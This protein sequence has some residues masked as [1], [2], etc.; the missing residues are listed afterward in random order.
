MERK[1][2]T[3]GTVASEKSHKNIILLLA[4]A[5]I[6]FLSRFY[7]LPF[8]YGINFAFGNVSIFLILRYY[9][10]TKAF[11][12]AAIVNLLEW[13]FLNPNFYILFFTLEI[14]FVG[15]LYKKTKYNVLFIDALYWIFVGSPAIAIVFYLHRGTIGNECYLIMVNKSINGFLNMFIADMIMSYIPIQKIAGLKKSKF[16]DLNKMLIHLTIASV[17]GPFLLYTLLD[18]WLSQ[19]RMNAE[20][21]SMLERTG[22]S[23]MSEASEWEI[24]ELRKVRL[25]SPLQLSKFSSIIEKNSIEEGIEILL[26]D[27]SHNV[28]ITNT[29]DGQYKEVYNWQ[30]NGEIT[31]ID[32]NTFQW[33]PA[34]K[35]LSFD[36]SRWSQ[37][38]Y[39]NTKTFDNVDL[40]ILVKKPLRNHIENAWENYL[41]KLLV[42]LG[43]SVASISVAIAM[44]SFLSRDLSKLTI[45]TTG[46]PEKLKRQESIEWPNISFSQV[47][48]L[49]E[50][51]KVMSENLV[52]LFS[53]TRI[54]NN[55]LLLQTRELEKSR[56]QMRRLAYYDTL[57]ELPNRLCFTEYLENLLNSPEKKKL[58]VMF[59]D[60]NRFKRIN[61]T[62]GHEIG[63]ILIKEIGKRLSY[64]LKEDSFVARL[65]GDEFV[66]VLEY[67]DI[68]MVSKAA[69]S[70]NKMLSDTV[71]IRQDGKVHELHVAGSIGISLYPDDA[72]EKSTLLK[73]A[74]IAMY[75]AKE[76]GE[77]TYKFYS[78]LT[79]LDTVEKLFLEQNL[80]KA[81]ERDEI[82]INYQPKMDVKTGEI[83]GAEALIR[84]NSPQHGLISPAEFI[85]L[86]EE[87]GIINQIG[88]WVLIEACKQNKMWQDKGYPKMRISVNLSLRQLK[89]NNFV[90]TVE[91]ALEISGL[92]S[93]YLELEITEGFFMKNS[94]YVIEILT[95]L[96]N[97][98]ICISI[99]DF[100]TGYSSLGR[101]K[102]LPVN[103]L[104]ID[105][106]F[107]TN[108]CCEES[109]KAIVV[110]IIEL[111]HSLG[112]R[113]LAE[114]VETIE[115]LNVLRE[116][117]CDEIQGYYLSKS[118]PAEEFEKFILGFM[119]EQIERS[120]QIKGMEVAYHE[121]KY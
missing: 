80:C 87:I 44:S 101:I 107:V 7:D 2:T 67:R 109:N 113:V 38:F 90:K 120:K 19:E 49:V 96:K 73:K 82:I 100:G 78:E 55:Q 11:I 119:A 72:F 117:H 111:A 81:L 76:T 25:K 20:V 104:K 26:V 33:L 27:K 14:L 30:D 86:A 64:F 59:I 114:G 21:C 97:M 69:A 51:F 63:D 4:L 61:D 99:D 62:L 5:V 112:L 88:E 65:G 42:L 116:L 83:S 106:S 31:K 84:W 47:N 23:I 17:F 58:A 36:L 94:E 105:R 52:N 110:A 102:E 37:G 68:E 121:K 115:D 24:K 108:I 54:M 70:I 10:V 95:E 43:F 71:V 45:S 29:D 60:L 93:K 3:T 40:V 6:S 50:N 75:A 18:G 77:N 32:D 92:E 85:P 22:S 66:V 34:H 56:E 28:Y 74:D 13:Y 57:T 9:G 103:I 79:E 12:V 16:A 48:S 98:G 35:G 89:G 1:I 8:S 41:N 39:I 46:L 15:I 118:L 53:E 91:R